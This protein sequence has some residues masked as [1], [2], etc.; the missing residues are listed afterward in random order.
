[1]SQKYNG[2]PDELVTKVPAFDIGERLA[3]ILPAIQKYDA[4]LVSKDNKPYGIIDDK[5][6]FSKRFRLK[7]DKNETIKKYARI[8]PRITDSTSIDD[9]MVYFYKTRV[10]GLPYVKDG[11]LRGMLKRET[12][13]KVMLSTGLAIGDKVSSI[14]TSPAF[15]IDAT[16]NL[17]QAK[18]AMD[19]NKISRLL[20]LENNK[21]MGI[22]TKSDIINFTTKGNEKLPELKTKAY[23]PSNVPISSIVNKNPV[24]ISSNAE[25]PDAI[26]LLVE[27]GVSSLVVVNRQTPVGIITV[28]DILERSISSRRVD[29]NS[30]IITGLDQY[31]YQYEDE[32]KEEAKNFV[33]KV[34]KLRGFGIN[35]ITLRVKRIKSDTYEIKARVSYGKSKMISIQASDYL[36]D[37]TLSKLLKNLR[38][39][40]IRKKER[41]T[42]QT[43]NYAY[44]D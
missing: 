14:M 3:N 13:L 36:L 21:F 7:F 12:I 39:E 18:A 28:T 29:Q 26:R 37:K 32:I 17:A 35:Y 22:I 34:N 6:L 15:A 31:T 5:T 25:I 23:T 19:K 1:M 41:S 9:A 27:N 33:A 38:D 40:I 10:K 4:V 43:G 30:I 24:V 16:A 42:G 44:V 11:K 8:V 20:V 2:I